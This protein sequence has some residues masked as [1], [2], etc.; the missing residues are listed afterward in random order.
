M[1]NFGSYIV[2]N[3]DWTGWKSVR[4]SKKLVTQY[5]DD[6]TIYT[7]YGYDGPEVLSCEIWKGEVPDGVK[8]SGLTQEQNDIDKADFEANYK[9]TAN[10][11]IEP[12]TADGRIDVHHTI[13]NRLQ[14]LN[15]RV[16]SFK[17]SYSGSLHN[18]NP[19]TEDSYNDIEYM[20]YDSS[21]SLIT[22]PTLSGSAV[23]T[24]IDFEPH[25]DYEIVGGFT[26]LP[27]TL[28]MGSTDQW[29]IGGVGVPDLPPEMYGSIAYISEVNIEAVQTSRVESDG[30]A[31]SYLPY[32]LY[33]YPT[34]K[35]RF[36]IKH[37]PGAQER[38][39]IYLE[40]FN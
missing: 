37:P 14:N 40:L 16:F 4:D 7:I 10:L 32:K 30:R 21:G 38:F 6:G 33:G 31:T 11:P 15:L 35:I 13:V 25:Y 3:F 1:I 24:V 20:L 34:N 23:K 5:D 2:R 12:K 28:H 8:A 39:Q 9:P 27:E 29:F 22:D 18:V 19:V 36:Y 26:D 17:T